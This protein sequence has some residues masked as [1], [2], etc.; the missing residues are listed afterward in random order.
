MSGGGDT[1]TTQ[2]QTTTQIPAWMDSAGQGLMQQAGGAVAGAQYNPL[3]L[4]AFNTA[5]IYGSMAPGA[6]GQSYN[7]FSDNANYQANPSWLAPLAGMLGRGGAGGGSFG[8]GGGGGGGYQATYDPAAISTLD[9]SQLE[10]MNPRSV[11]DYN[12]QDYMSPYTGAVV[13]SALGD[14]DRSRQMTLG[15]NAARASGAGAF[16]GSRSGVIDAL[17]NSEFDRNSASTAAQFRDAAY[18]DA[19]SLIGADINNATAADQANMGQTLQALLANAGFE[20]AGAQFN[21]GQANQLD[22][23]QIQAAAQRAAAAASANASMYGSRMGYMGQQLDA[24]GLLAQLGLG[25]DL[26]AATLRG[27]TAQQLMQFGQNGMGSGLD[28][29]NQIYNQPMQD[30]GWYGGLLGGLPGAN[31]GSSNT[32]TTAPGEGGNDAAQ[33]ASN[34]A[35]MYMMYSG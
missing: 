16:G 33:W 9:L 10:R 23:T 14:I 25:A 17:T 8:G 29:G 31:T 22:Q 28:M 7:V 19:N 3:Q 6:L 20:N 1:Q 18:R 4:Q 13:D 26:N 34:L 2:Q 12:V 5:G 32:T 21:A 15:S 11:L 35:M 30:L 27:N 24:A